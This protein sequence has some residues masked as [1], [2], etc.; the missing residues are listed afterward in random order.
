MI[1]VSMLESVTQKS[2]R[3]KS[4]KSDFKVIISRQSD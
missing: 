1:K 3:K 4:V 2:T